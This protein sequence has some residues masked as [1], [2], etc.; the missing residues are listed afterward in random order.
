VAGHLPDNAGRQGS[1]IKLM[2]NAHHHLTHLEE[3]GLMR[4]A[5]TMPELEYLFRH[6]LVQNAAYE[7]LLVQ[8]RRHL[9][10]AVAEKL[11][12]LY[13]QQ[14][15]LAPVL[16]HHFAAAGDDR[17]ALAYFTQAGDAAARTYANAEA[18]AQYQHALQLTAT[19]SVGDEQM[20]HLGRQ[21]GRAL[22]HLGRHDEALAAY[23]QMEAFARRH[24]NRPME[25]QALILRATIHSAPTA[26]Y[27]IAQAQALAEQA[28][29]LARE[30]ND[31][32]AEAKILWNLVLA[33]KF[34]GHWPQVL[35]YAEQGIALARRL[36]LREQLAYLF[37]DAYPAY[38]SSGQIARAGEAI[39]EAVALWRE[40]ENL[41]MLVDGLSSA[42][43]L[44]TTLGNYEQALAMAQ[45][46]YDLALAIGNI[47]GQSYSLSQIGMVWLTWGQIG[48]G[49]A[50]L[51]K[52][53]ALGEQA[54]FAIPLIMGPSI[55]G[56]IYGEIGQVE[57]GIK[58]AQK[59]LHN[60]EQL[61]SWQIWP[62]AILAQLY[63]AKQDGARAEQYI[64]QARQV[65]EL[66]ELNGLAH[67]AQAEARLG[68]LRGDYERAIQVIDELLPVTRAYSAQGYLADLLYYKGE[69]LRRQGA[70]DAART[71][72]NEAL[73]LAQ[74][75]NLRY[76]LLLS[77]HALSQLEN[78]PAAAVG[79]RGQA[80]GLV[81]Q[82]ADSLPADWRANFLA[83]AAV[84]EI[85]GNQGT[86]S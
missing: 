11:E 67:L 25:L 68:L 19:E 66:S 63:V 7:S 13:P 22:E 2:S 62:L 5:Q 16:A 73:A 50:D 15:E 43:Y 61:P 72:L 41:P 8:Q 39:E 74:P 24:G 65:A 40:L 70:A 71:V 48:Q 83:T 56:L 78:D 54:G 1:A 79:L 52:A 82:V 53:I 44:Q 27:D 28:L 76:T 37:N 58:L 77:Y 60:A 33:N 59:A 26:R 69:A 85:V 20:E 21:Y 57:Q 45:E 81:Q 38:L 14:E 49:M 36:N 29:G 3:A 64:Q 75:L 31:E 51:E 42:A 18:A 12:S 47:W 84:R 86:S 35:A 23:Q 34:V 4:L 32:A 9:H 80:A 6:A 17:R 46:G 30:L 10:Q 55:Q